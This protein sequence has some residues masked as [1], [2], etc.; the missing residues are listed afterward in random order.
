MIGILIALYGAYIFIVFL[1]NIANL[2]ILKVD[3]KLNKNPL[4]ATFLVFVLNVTSLISTILLIALNI[5]LITK[6]F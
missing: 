6:V 2:N 3:Y 4:K 5:K 1:K